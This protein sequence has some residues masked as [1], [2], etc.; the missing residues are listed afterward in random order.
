MISFKLIESGHIIL[1][2]WQEKSEEKQV[3][4]IIA[5]IMHI[6]FTGRYIFSLKN[7]SITSTL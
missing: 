5:M 1:P 3:I 2:N 7:T 6:I 4:L